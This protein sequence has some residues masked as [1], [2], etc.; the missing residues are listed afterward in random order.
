[1]KALLDSFLVLTKQDRLC[2]CLFVTSD[3]YFMSW[4]RRLNVIQHASLL[5]IGDCSKSQAREYFEQHVRHVPDQLSSGIDFDECFEVFGGKLAHLQDYIAEYVGSGGITKRT[6]LPFEH[7]FLFL[8][9]SF[10]SADD[11]FETIQQPQHRPIIF[12][13]MLCSTFTSFIPC[14]RPPRRRRTRTRLNRKRIL[15]TDSK[16]TPLFSSL[17]LQILHLFQR[18]RRRLIQQ[19]VN[20]EELNSLR[21]N[22]FTSSNC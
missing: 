22:Y 14:P 7:F 15:Q 3:A 2:H 6:I 16:S 5:S 17:L 13:L 9:F 1:M 20:P 10:A 8:P 12:R 21:I 19:I 4:L 11:V 18:L